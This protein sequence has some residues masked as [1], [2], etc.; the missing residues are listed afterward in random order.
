MILYIY[1][2]IIPGINKIAKMEFYIYNNKKLN[3]NLIRGNILFFSALLG[4]L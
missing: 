4:E 2:R 3:I 1:I